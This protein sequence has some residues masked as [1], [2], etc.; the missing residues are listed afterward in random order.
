MFEIDWLIPGNTTW[1]VKFFRSTN[2]KTIQKSLFESVLIANFT[3]T[4]VLL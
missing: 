2:V 1:V 4:I 3:S